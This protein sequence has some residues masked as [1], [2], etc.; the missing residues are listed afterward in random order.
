MRAARWRFALT[1]L[2]PRRRLLPCRSL[3]VINLVLLLSVSVTSGFCVLNVRADEQAV[4][5]VSERWSSAISNDRADL[6]EQMLNKHIEADGDPMSLLNQ[7][8]PNGKSALMVASKQGDLQLV[9]RL[10]TLG[11]DVNESTLTSGT[12]LMF[13]VLGNHVELAKWLHESG[14]NINSKGSNGWSAATI[15]G[16]KGQ[17]KMLRWLIDS[18]ADINSPDVYRFTPLMR[19]VDNRHVEAVKMLLTR[20]QASVDFTD[21]SDNS[22][23]HYAVA[24]NQLSVIRMLLSHGANPEQ[25]NRNGITPADLAKQFPEVLTVFSQ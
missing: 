15:A 13:A 5:S 16:A 12:P 21:E 11:A 18:G 3:P 4:P 20:G 8:A 25:A 22:A 6:L 17:T 14:A 24:N 1:K 10:V 9:Q 2:S 19:A 7:D 23:L